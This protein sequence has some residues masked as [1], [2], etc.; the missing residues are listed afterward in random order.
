[1]RK[2]GL[3]GGV[4]YGGIV[5]GFGAVG[6]RSAAFGAASAASNRAQYTY[7]SNLKF[8]PNQFINGVFGIK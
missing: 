5:T 8:K 7:F 6:N 1:M 3:V 4:G 2:S